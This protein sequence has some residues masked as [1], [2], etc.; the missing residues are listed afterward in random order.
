MNDEN[1]TPQVVDMDTV[2]TMLV[3]V[4]ATLGAEMDVLVPDT[5]EVNG[6]VLAITH[7]AGA[8]IGILTL[9]H[10]N[11]I[12]HANE[13][14]RHLMPRTWAHGFHEGPCA[15]AHQELAPAVE[16][17]LYGRLGGAARDYFGHVAET[18]RAHAASALYDAA[19]YAGMADAIETSPVTEVAEHHAAGG[20]DAA[21]A[22][23][24]SRTSALAGLVALN[25]LDTPE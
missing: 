19:V 21:G 5:D 15:V 7:M 1:P 23:H 17:G 11:L 3:D 24:R 14:T 18:S 9:L 2:E 10:T 6:Q 20:I 8:A 4:L 12:P 25:A 13:P 16:A 22:H